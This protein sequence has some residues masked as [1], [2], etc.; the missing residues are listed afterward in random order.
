MSN[1]V[2]PIRTKKDYEAALTELEHLWG[3]K[4]GTLEGDHLDVLVT[5]VDAHE[6]IHYPMDPPDPIEAIKFRMEQQGAQGEDS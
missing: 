5:L 2:R 1:N 4:L 6:T 3:G